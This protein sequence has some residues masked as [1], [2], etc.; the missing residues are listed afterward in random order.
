LIDPMM[1]FDPS[2]IYQ[3]LI[4][5]APPLA[6]RANKHKARQSSHA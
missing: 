4:D 5:S 6:L 3:S 2:L 1:S